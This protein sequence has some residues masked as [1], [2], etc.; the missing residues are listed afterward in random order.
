MA[1]AVLTCSQAERAISRDLDGLLSRRERSRL[2]GHIRGCG[3]CASFVDFQ[4]RRRRTL[5]M[6][7]LVPAPIS[8]QVFRVGGV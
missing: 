5:R 2:G 8:L 7:R 1:A 4:R 6:L 3:E